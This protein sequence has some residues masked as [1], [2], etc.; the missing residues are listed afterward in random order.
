MGCRVSMLC[1]A[2]ESG[3]DLRNSGGLHVADPAAYLIR[4]LGE[5]DPSW[6]AALLEM[7][8]VSQEMDADRDITTMWGRVNDQA[9][10]LGILNLAHGLGMHLLSVEYLPD[11][12]N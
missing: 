8:I 6:L 10:L 4:F 7:G 3:I 5:F 9:A 11:P 12:Q 1:D 2:Y